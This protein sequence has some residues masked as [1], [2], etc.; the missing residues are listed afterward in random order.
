M[1]RTRPPRRGHSNGSALRGQRGWCR[2]RVCCLYVVPA[3]CVLVVKAGLVIC[4]GSEGPCAV[5]L[6]EQ[7]PVGLVLREAGAELR[8]LVVDLAR[9]LAEA[10][11]LTLELDAG[12]V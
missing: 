4:A 12:L 1:R 11:R 8:R 6:D 3:K 10:E 2:R 5:G 7:R 9:S